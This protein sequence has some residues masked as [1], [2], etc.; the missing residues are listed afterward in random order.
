[1]SIIPLILRYNLLKFEI[2]E[3]NLIK[4]WNIEGTIEPK[5][6]FGLSKKKNTLDVQL[7]LTKKKLISSTKV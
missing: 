5:K 1:M 7:K 3:V 6:Y 2:L 4:I